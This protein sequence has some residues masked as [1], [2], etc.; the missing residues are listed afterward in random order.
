MDP[1]PAIHDKALE[2]TTKQFQ[3]LFANSHAE[4]R[5]NPFQ[6]ITNFA[7]KAFVYLSGVWVAT[8]YGILGS[9]SQILTFDEQA[10]ITSLLPFNVFQ[11]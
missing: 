5:S 10:L 6:I 7:P 1:V 9:K 11:M 8:I 3:N 2:R 4:P